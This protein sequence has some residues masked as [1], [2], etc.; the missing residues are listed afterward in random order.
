MS[1]NRAQKPNPALESFKVLVGEWSTEGTHPY[2]PNET[3]HGTVIIEWTEGGAFLMTHSHVEDER[4]PDGVAIFGSDDASG[5][6]FM[7]YFDER[8]V[9]RKYEV[10]F[11][12]NTLT[13]W[14]DEP[15]FSQRMVLSI[16]PDHQTIFSKGEMNRD[17]KGW[18]PDLQLTYTRIK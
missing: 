10:S 14:R 3:L 7:L 16:S 13:Y 6:F 5:E 4:F 17:G 2:V 8:G 9:S 18:E 1:S 15:S 11:K 12:M